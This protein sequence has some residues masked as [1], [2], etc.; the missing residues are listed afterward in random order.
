MTGGVP[1][2]HVSALEA[3]LPV[4]LADG[5]APQEEWGTTGGGPVVSRFRL[6]LSA[7]AVR[8]LVEPAGIQLRLVAG[9]AV[10]EARVGRVRVIADVVGS[11]TERGTLLAEATA[12]RLGGLLPVPPGL[13]ALA[14]PAIEGPPGLKAV[15]PRAVELDLAALLEHLLQPAGVRVTARIRRIRI[16]RDFLEVECDTEG[17]GG[18]SS[19]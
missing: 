6:R 4:P 8:R 10:L 7:H 16:E 2:I 15:P 11:V 14:L 1:A 3:W 13:A 17:D 5:R 19:A 9:G 18:G 12:L